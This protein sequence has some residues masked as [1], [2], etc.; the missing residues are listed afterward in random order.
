M[1]ALQ[2]LLQSGH[3]REAF[4]QSRGSSDPRVIFL[5][6]NAALELGEAGYARDTLEQLPPFAD[7]ALEA[8]RLSW[9]GWSYLA[10]GDTSTHLR[11]TR[12]AV[13]VC[14][15]HLSLFY[16]A[17]SLPPSDALPVLLESMALARTPAEET[18][19]AVALARTLELLGRFREGL[20]YASL[21]YLRKPEHP[22]TLLAYVTLSLAGSQEVRLIDLVQLLQPVVQHGDFAHKAAAFNLLA[23][24]HLLLGQPGKALEAVEQAIELVGKEYLALVCLVAVRVYLALGQRDRAFSMVQAAQLTP[25]SYPVMKGNLQL[26]WGLVLYPAPEAEAAFEQARESYGILAPVG[27]LVARAYLAHIRQEPLD[28]ASLESLQQWSDAALGMYPL[29]RQAST[30]KEYRLQVLGSGQLIGPWGPIPLR[31]R[32]LEM[33]VLLLSHPE[34]WEREALS[35]ALYGGARP[36]AFKAEMSRLK[37]ALGAIIQPKPW[38]VTQPISADFLEVRYWLGRGEVAA[39]LGRYTG[40]LLPQSD[41]PG[42]EE[43]RAELLEDLRQAV[44]ASN[45]PDLMFGLAQKVSDD[46]ELLERLLEILPRADW[47]SPVV[48]SRIRRLRQ[49]I[50]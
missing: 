34:G 43:L 4:E 50:L 6:V 40:S 49:D 17:N 11:L 45:N 37:N 8:D 20:S 3:F 36:R 35:E 25:L 47:R 14:P 10:L 21:A 41:A 12:E 32:G 30:S 31:P 15:G 7:P 23:D 48:L 33:L 13:Q 2:E 29:L 1:Q 44:L 9:L 19:A 16:L 26:A 39:A 38:R 5:H 22:N 18:Q 24:L 46:L 27:N 28:Q 42:I